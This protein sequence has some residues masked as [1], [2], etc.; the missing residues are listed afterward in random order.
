MSEI[1]R[2]YNPALFFTITGVALFLSWL[3]MG[4][5][6]QDILSNGI[7]CDEY[8]VREMLVLYSG[9][10]R[11][12]VA[13]L[14][15]L[16]LGFSGA[17]L[18]LALRNPLASPTTMGVSAGA[19]LALVIAGLFFPATLVYGREVIALVGAGVAAALV[20]GLMARRDFSPIS[21]VLTGLIVS[22]YFGALASL[23][24]LLNDRYLASLFIWGAG[25][26]S[27]QSW[28]VAN[29]LWPQLLVLFGLSMVMV[30][31]FSLLVLGDGS[32]S[33]LGVSPGMIRFFAVSIAI[34]L[35]AFVTSAVGVIGFIGLVAP[36]IVRLCGAR[37]VL[38]QLIWSALIGAA[39][40]WMTDAVI[41]ILAGSLRE[42]VPTG[43]VT[44]LL[45]SPL[46]LFLIPRM[47]FET[48]V[49]TNEVSVVWRQTAGLKVLIVMLLI[50]IGVVAFAVTFGRDADLGWAFDLSGNWDDVYQWRVPRVIAAFSAGIMLALAGMIL[51]RLTGNIMASPEVLGINAGAMMGIGVCIYLVVGVTPEIMAVGALF[52]SS[53]VL[54]TLF[55][56]G[57]R[58][59]FQPE[60]MI[61]IGVA[62]GA[63]IDALIGALAATGDLRSV[64]LLRIMAG[65]TYGVS[66]EAACSALLIGCVLMVPL[67]SGSRALDVLNLGEKVSLALGVNVRRSRF[68]LFAVASCLTAGATVLVGPLSF[69]GLMTPHIARS[70]GLLQA[71][72]QMVVAALA[73]GSLM[74]VA[75]WIG[76]VIDY[77]YE[78]PAGLLS[79]LVGT[80]LLLILMSRQNAF[81]RSS[82][83]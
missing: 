8:N 31:P 38:S 49:Q 48:V 36:M 28:D 18:Q 25:S 33:S 35:A 47:K 1:Q 52:G 83:A 66:L 11:L 34:A 56:F 20:F 40:L 4:Q 50:S 7:S 58:S 73:G 21:L 62:L 60:R 76:R 72:F 46:L 15:G 70:L 68:V 37:R 54:A 81:T 10:P 71:R 41:Q 32:T 12:S 23:L 65:S 17:I 78:M 24:V 67:L 16:A 14:S 64:H 27:Q 79:A 75:D 5:D 43:A 6:L 19:Y 22:L 61:L 13:I 3:L 82:N 44:A 39:L 42:F 63:L 74:V 77:P 57:K 30:R 53:I 51:Q 69:V 26:L 80:P 59:G 45:G 9:L 55:A 2:N 29:I